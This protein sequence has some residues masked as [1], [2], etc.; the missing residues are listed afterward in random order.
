M[1][2]AI[3]ATLGCLKWMRRSAVIV[4]ITSAPTHTYLS[5]HTHIYTRLPSAACLKRKKKKRRYT[6]MVCSYCGVIVCVCVCR[7]LSAHNSC[8]SCPK[9]IVVAYLPAFKHEACMQQRLEIAHTLS[10]L[11]RISLSAVGSFN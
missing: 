2:I 10:Y 9:L 3:V 8:S 6:S 7:N 1:F 4:C 5:T 11:H